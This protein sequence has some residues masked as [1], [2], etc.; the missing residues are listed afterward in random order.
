MS[1]QGRFDW[2]QAV[3]DN[4]PGMTVMDATQLLTYCG[5]GQYLPAVMNASRGDPPGGTNSLVRQFFNMVG[6]NVNGDP[7]SGLKL[8]AF[9]QL[10]TAFNVWGRNPG[11]SVTDSSG[12]SGCIPEGGS[13]TCTACPSSAYDWDC[14]PSKAKIDHTISIT[15]S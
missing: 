15:A 13:Q 12:Y 7:V 11:S 9:R 3:K 5:P 1:V 10:A 6:D 4:Y 8:G 2:A 14:T